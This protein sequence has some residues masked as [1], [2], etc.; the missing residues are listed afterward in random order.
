MAGLYIH[1]PFCKSR[2]IYCGFYST[3]RRHDT[4]R[5][6]RA[7]CREMD[8][9]RGYISEPPT[10]IYIGGGTP[11]Q[12]PEGQ[13][14]ALFGAMD[15]SRAEE[16]TMECNPDDIT[17]EY[18][19]S[20]GELP[21][22]RVSMG[23]QTF[24]DNRLRLLRRRH[25]AAEVH[26]AVDLLRREGIGNVS[27]DLIYGFPGET[28]EQWLGDVN[29]ALELRPE[30]ISAYCLSFEEGTPLYA[31]LKEGQVGECGEE[32]CRAMY[33]A[34]VDKLTAAGY[35]HYEIS[36]FA[37][38]GRRSRHN[39]GYWRSVPYMGVGA[40]AHSFDGDSRQWNVAD[41]DEYMDCV[42]RGAVPMERETLGTATRYNDTVML[43]LRTVEGIDLEAIAADFGQGYAE[44]CK[45]QAA[46]YAEGG[47]LELSGNSLRLTRKGIF[48]SDM[49]ASD[50]MLV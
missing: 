36:N 32:S 15:I 43:S 4:M 34:L 29:R 44:M 18:A 5:Y 10:T 3:T 14:H 8:L 38:P 17:P 37:L 26:R 39:S 45:K 2:C 47:L 22:S 35:E 13:L 48:V 12:L 24:S 6:I 11:S 30:H 21:I 28:V 19:R 1:I 31:M 42:E 9:R 41:I 20:I 7:L 33:F 25:D 40:A 49:I 23:V 50:L 27:I 46:R 16:I